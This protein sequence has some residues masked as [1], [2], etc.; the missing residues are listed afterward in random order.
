MD[1]YEEE[2]N[3]ERLLVFRPISILYFILI[4]FWTMLLLPFILLTGGVF[5]RALGMPS[6]LAFIVLLLSLFGSHVN[7]PVMTVS[8]PQPMMSF[9]EVDFFGVRWYMPEFTYKRRKTVIAINLGGALIPT[10]VSLYLLLFIVP[11]CETNLMI[12]YGKIFAAFLIVTFIVHAVAKPVRGL[13]IATPSFVPP[14]ASALAAL[15][16]FP[17]YTRSN[18]F[19]IAYVA[20]TLGTLVGADLLNLDKVSRLG[21]PLVSIGGAGTFD[22]IYMTGIMAVLLVMLII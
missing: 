6:Y 1:G 5:S 4:L 13:G 8:S 22:G 3:S 2:E 9:R 10:F 16:I 21:S 15:A 7:I 17:I 11:A 14:F 19:I 18:P 12:A 20:G